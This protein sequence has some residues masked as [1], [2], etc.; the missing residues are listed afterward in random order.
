MI[1]YSLCV[2]RH[3]RRMS[4]SQ[5]TTNCTCASICAGRPSLMLMVVVVMV[6]VVAAAAAVRLQHERLAAVHPRAHVARVDGPS[7]F[8]R[9]H[10][11]R[12][13]RPLVHAE[14]LLRRRLARELGR[15][16]RR[17]VGTILLDDGEGEPARVLRAQQRV[18]HG[19]GALEVAVRRDHH[20]NRRPA[21]HFLHLR[22]EVHAR[23]RLPEARHEQ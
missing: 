14:R 16:A 3:C 10:R 15:V 18:G 13:H 7:A 6:G 4:T 8:R 17:V 11:I 12:V 1:A 5:S 19:L 21:V 23:R 20:E 9:V 22:I 2:A